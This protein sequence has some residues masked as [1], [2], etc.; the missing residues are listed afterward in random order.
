MTKES[1]DDESKNIADAPT[2]EDVDFI[3]FFR[4]LFPQLIPSPLH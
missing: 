1:F 3:V 4:N 2:A